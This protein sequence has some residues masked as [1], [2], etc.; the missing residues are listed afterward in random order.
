MFV[1]V[2]IIFVTI[3]FHYLLSYNNYCPTIA[4]FLLQLFSCYNIYLLVV[5][6]FILQLSSYCSYHL[7]ITIVRWLIST[8]YIL[9]SDMNKNLTK[10]KSIA[11]KLDYLLT[12]TTSFYIKLILNIFFYIQEIKEKHIYIYIWSATFNQNP[13]YFFLTQISRS[14]WIFSHFTYT[15]F[16]RITYIKW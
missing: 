4:I 1:V 15:N 2:A 6:I 16:L 11:F 7:T 9:K 13:L 3:A 12:T 10:V 8:K 14:V 5:V